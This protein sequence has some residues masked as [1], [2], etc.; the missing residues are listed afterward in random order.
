MNQLSER[1]TQ[2]L[3]FENQYWRFVGAK[4]RAIRQRFDLTPTQYY[5]LLN[6]LID[7]PEALAAKPLLIRRLQAQRETRQARR[8][9]RPQ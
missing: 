1:D 4:E 5:V 8:G 6:E 2:M 7:R 3:D 9:M